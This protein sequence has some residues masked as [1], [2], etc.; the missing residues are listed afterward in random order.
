MAHL[1]ETSVTPDENLNTGDAWMGFMHDVLLA[2]VF[3]GSQMSLINKIFI[4]Y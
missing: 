1:W 3:G 2:L 4:P